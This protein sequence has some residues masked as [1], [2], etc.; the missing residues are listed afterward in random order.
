MLPAPNN[1]DAWATTPPPLPDAVV[2]ATIDHMTGETQ[3]FIQH[4]TVGVT[5]L[6]D[7]P[8]EGAATLTPA[9][10]ATA[11]AVG[12]QHLAE[13]IRRDIERL[14]RDEPRPE[15]DQAEGQQWTQRV[16]GP[17]SGQTTGK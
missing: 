5:Q 17:A 10:R 7:A 12:C 13:P 4:Y 15:S 8:Q 11:F 14:Q 6:R 9:E 16:S 1:G 2:D 3:A